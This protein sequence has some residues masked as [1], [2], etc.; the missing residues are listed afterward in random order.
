MKVLTIARY[1]FLE[2]VKSKVLYNTIFLGCIFLVSSFV[3]KEFTYGVP[4]RVALDFGLG[5]LSISSVGIGIFFGATLISKELEGRT[6]YM[7]LSRPV[8][9]WE[10]LLGRILGMSSMLFLNVMILSLMC[11]AVYWSSSG[12][13]SHSLIYWSILFS[14]FEALIVLLVTVFFSL[15]TN[16]TMTVVSSLIIFILGHA[17]TSTMAYEFVNNRGFLKG[18]LKVYSVFFP[19]FSRLNIKDF[20]LYQNDLPS[21]FLMGNVLYSTIYII[22]LFLLSSFILQKKDLT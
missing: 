9:R 22:A 3:A 8:W 5:L 6:I 15:L 19:N 10:Y 21:S 2:V 18:L 11:L 4:E 16:V 12:N 14:Y 13:L 7:I 1:T 17:L 20:V